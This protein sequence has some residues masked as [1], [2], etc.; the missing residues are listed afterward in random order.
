MK[1]KGK[2][3]DHLSDIKKDNPFI[4]PGSYFKD[5]NDRLKQRLNE[6][7]IH[8]ETQP[9]VR[10]LPRYSWAVTIAAVVAGI[11]LAVKFWIVKPST[12]EWSNEEIAVIIQDE[13]YDLDEFDLE[14]GINQSYNNKQETVSVEAVSY[15]DEIINY[16][17]DEQIDYESI[18]SEL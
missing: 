17:I 9:A 18:I 6:E 15:K 4:V 7:D 14:S 3:A 11:M 16:L 12:P 13:L 8:K 10:K 2:I 1:N 5:F